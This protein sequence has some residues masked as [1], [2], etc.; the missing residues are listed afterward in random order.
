MN[1]RLAGMVCDG[2]GTVNEDAAG[3]LGDA[4]DVSSAWVL[5][6]VTGINETSVYPGGSDAGWFVDQVQQELRR[7]LC[8]TLPLPVIM[9]ALVDRL[10]AIR[11][12]TLPK[13]YDPPACCLLLVRKHEGRWDAARLG[14][15][16]LLVA[17]NNGQFFQYTEFPLQWLD[18]EL[19][20][21]T[22]PLR[23]KSMTQAGIIRKFRPLIRKSR[24]ARNRPGG[25]GI[26]E[27]NPA[28]LDFVQYIAMENPR[29]ILLCTDGFYRLV[30]TYGAYTDEGLMEGACKV[31]VESLLQKLRAIEADDAGCRRYP[32]IK[33]RDDATAI[34]LTAAK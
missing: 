22:G 27:A 18:H 28:C 19:R 5:D 29:S 14:D 24:Q 2:A 15:S 13:G 30:E 9:S 25:Y 10:G 23:L 4:R 34:C 20:I 31:G 21:K 1:L 26:L 11:K 16:S 32:R 17:E 6:G 33:P 7:L 8:E 3:L 12:A